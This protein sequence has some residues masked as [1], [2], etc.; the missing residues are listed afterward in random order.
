M[1]ILSF[2]NVYKLNQND[3]AVLVKMYGV[4][5]LFT[6]RDWFLKLSGNF[7]FEYSS[8]FDEVVEDTIVEVKEEEQIVKSKK[9]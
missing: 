3:T 6:P 7:N 2:I 8:D 4:D 5:K 1:N 9:Q